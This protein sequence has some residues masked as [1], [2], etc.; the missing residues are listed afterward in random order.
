MRCLAYYA[1]LRRSN[2]NATT[3]PHP[4][5]WSRINSTNLHSTRSIKA[6]KELSTRPK[7]CCSWPRC[8]EEVTRRPNNPRGRKADQDELMI[9]R[10][11]LCSDL[12]KACTG[13]IT[14]RGAH[15]A[16]KEA[17][18]CPVHHENQA[19]EAPVPP[20]RG[21]LLPRLQN[22]PRVSKF[23]TYYDYL[24]RDVYISQLNSFSCLIEL[25][26]SVGD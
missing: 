13:V 5:K 15:I 7:S 25:S 8:H 24:Y 23:F 11:C 16:V 26:W 18:W 22:R 19:R 2:D 17:I 3:T 1:A 6:C 12:K 9:S 21:S 4:S 10:A 20:P 14:T